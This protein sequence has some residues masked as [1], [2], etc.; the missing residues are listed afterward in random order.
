MRDFISQIKSL[1]LVKAGGKIQELTEQIAES[2]SLDNY[3]SDECVL[4]SVS[5]LIDLALTDS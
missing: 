5:A 4:A 1:C 3:C 2:F